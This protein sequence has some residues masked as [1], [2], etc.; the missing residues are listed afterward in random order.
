MKTLTIF[1]GA[2]HTLCFFL[3]GIG[4][5]DYHVCIKGPGECRI[6]AKLKEKNA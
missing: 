2:F 4:A 5:I 1:I 6:E 3:G